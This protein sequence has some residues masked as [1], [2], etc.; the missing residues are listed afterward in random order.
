VP[1]HSRSAPRRTRLRVIH[2]GPARA[3][4]GVASV[5]SAYAA[6][7]LMDVY[8]VSIIPTVSP[9]P[10]WRRHP[11]GFVGVLHACL[12]AWKG[13]SLFHVHMSVRGS[14][15][16]KGIVVL[17]AKALGHPVVLH[18]HGSQFHHYAASGSRVRRRLVQYVLDRA[19]V[20]LAL[21]EEWRRRLSRL[22]PRQRIV[23]IGNPVHLPPTTS[24][25]CDHNTVVFL[26]RLGERKGI[27]TLIDAIGILQRRGVASSF[28][29]AGDG[30]VE[31][32]RRRVRTLPDP[33]RVRV[34]GWVSPSEVQRMLASASIFCLPSHDEGVPVALLEAMSHGLAC[35]VTAAGGMGDVIVDGVNGLIVRRDDS[36][37]LA[38]ALQGLVEDPRMR[39][40]FGD[41]AREHVLREN[42]L[43]VVIGQLSA[44]YSTLG[45]KPQ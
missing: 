11:R 24:N 29:L 2:V 12:E 14:F 16:R 34:P 41:R 18:I 36:A 8:E 28:V 35:V 5:I 45:Y 1:T 23:V 40:A 10:A 17:V 15:W 27:P 13:P 37:A 39:H 7:S 32:T 38:Q 43:D 19:D 30:D 33:M 3:Q 44:V 6:S 42:S 4:G 22:C 26:G 9:G 31:E 20:V 21:S 25:V